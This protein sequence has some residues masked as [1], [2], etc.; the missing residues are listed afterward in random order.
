MKIEATHKALRQQAGYTLIELSISVAIIAVLV[1]TGLYGVPRILASNNVS[2]LTQQMALASANFSKVAAQS[3][4]SKAFANTTVATGVASIGQMGIWP[5]DALVKNSTGVVTK[6]THQ[7]G[8]SILSAPITATNALTNMAQDEGVWIRMDGIPQAQCFA[9][10]S[11]LINQ[12]VALWAD[13]SASG[14]NFVEPGKNVVENTGTSP[15]VSGVINLANLATMCQTSAG[16][17]GA[18]KPVSVYMLSA[19]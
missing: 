16:A 11:A 2:K 9:V 17:A 12:S 4:N 13:G 5:D 19:F 10:G 15:K 6:I 14:T 18:G 1:M 7:F 8:G 3:P